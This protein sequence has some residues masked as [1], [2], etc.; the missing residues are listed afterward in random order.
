MTKNTNITKNNK[1]CIFHACGVIKD[2][3][4]RFLKLLLLPTPPPLPPSLLRVCNLLSRKLE[5][6]RFFLFTEK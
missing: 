4:Q 1:V 3:A 6:K 5:T 2:S